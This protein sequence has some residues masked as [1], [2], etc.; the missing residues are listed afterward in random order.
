M[1]KVSFSNRVAFYFMSATAVLT[2]VIFMTI[3]GVVYRTVYTHLDDDLNAESLELFNSIVIL[4]DQ[5]IFANPNEWIENEH[6]QIEVNPIFIQFADSSGKI[7]RKSA[8]LENESLRILKNKY[9][10]IDFN[11]FI[12]G[13][14][15]YQLQVPMKNHLGKLLGYLSVAMPLDETIMVL[16]NLRMVLIIAFPI[17]L[18]FLYFITDL[19]ARK[20]IAP[21]YQ[22]Y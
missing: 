20:S 9:E 3:Y 6:G 11:D 1:R 7:L 8:N 12:S 14:R 4:S 19:I 5:I 15:I 17:V 18:F 16:R 22:A 13:S 10:R 21:V 2:V